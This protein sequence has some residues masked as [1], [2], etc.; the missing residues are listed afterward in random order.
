M[1]WAVRRRM[2]GS[3]LSLF[4]V[5]DL[6]TLAPTMLAGLVE[7][8]RSLLYP[9]LRFAAIWSDAPR[10]T[11]WKRAWAV[12]QSER[13]RLRVILEVAIALRFGLNEM[14]FRDICRDCDYPV[15]SLESS[16]ITWRFDTKG[17]WRY[18][19]DALPEHRLAVVSQVAF[20]EAYAVGL[21]AF[22]A[23]N[24]GEGWMLPDTL[25]LADYDLGHDH[26]A[27]EHQPVA[28]ALGPRFHAW[29]LEHSVEESWE[30]CKR[31]A[32]VLA[33]LIPPP[34]AEKKTN[35]EDGDAVAV[36]LFG[37]P[38]DTDLFGSPVYPKPRKR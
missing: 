34:D 2:G 25:R 22:L 7:F 29:L 33:T 37:I 6:P 17:F 9:H 24:N 16:E 10:S 31:H 4:V 15:D 36:D 3:N 28:F 11:S 12:T 23:Q 8:T 30:E 19:R 32:E 20:R 26:R 35:P 38:L 13:L 14:E 5:E 27:K 21:E 1:D 18:Q